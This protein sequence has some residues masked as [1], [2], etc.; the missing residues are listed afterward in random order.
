MVNLIFPNGDI[1]DGVVFQPFVSIGHTIIIE[2]ETQ[3]YLV[4]SIEHQMWKTPANF[5]IQSMDQMVVNVV[6]ERKKS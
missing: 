4:K 1:I 2:G 6:L 5:D 3:V